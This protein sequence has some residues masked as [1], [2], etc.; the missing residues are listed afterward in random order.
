MGRF[1]EDRRGSILIETAVVIPLLVV[2]LFSLAEFGEAFT[3]KRRNAQVA[4]TAA[5]L[6]AQVSCVMTSDL[7]DIA[8]IAATILKPYSSSASIAGLRITSVVQNANSATVQWSHAT[9]TLTAAQTGASFSLPPS[10]VSQSQTV[11]VGEASYNFVP[12]VGNFLTGGVTFS[13][14][15]FN[16]P[17]LSNTVALQTSC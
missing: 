2:I 4:S 9:G 8:N 1:L 16:K 7:Q 14:Q 11:I 5:D 17:R 3:I 6:V 10:L 12:P 13:A 15:A